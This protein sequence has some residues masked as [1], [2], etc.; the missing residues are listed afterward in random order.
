M[1]SA[2]LKSATFKSTYL[3]DRLHPNAA[4]YQVMSDVW[5]TVVHDLLR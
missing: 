5:N 1:Y 3:A 2:F 4:G